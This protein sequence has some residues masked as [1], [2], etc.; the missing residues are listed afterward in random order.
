MLTQAQKMQAPACGSE[1][2]V[3]RY[4]LAANRPP[5][6]E[7]SLLSAK[8]WWS[9]VF[10]I[11]LFLRTLFRLV[12]ICPHWHKGPPITL[13]VTMPSR[14]SGDGSVFGRETHIT[15]LDCGQKFAYD[16]KTRRLEDFW[17]VHDADALAGV[18]QKFDGY[19]SPLRGLA[20][21]MGTPKM[22]VSMSE[23]VRSV[24]R[25]AELMKGRWIELLKSTYAW[26]RRTSSV[27][28]YYIEKAGE[29]VTHVFKHL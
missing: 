3:A 7:R 24:L 28:V 29:K 13:R 21:R 22:R 2:S 16:R 11:P 8:P 10:G 1:R 23:P 12:Y 25:S 14:E 15:C 20:A 27:T 26:K 17:G 4:S 5:K 19:F 9:M 18:R 6:A